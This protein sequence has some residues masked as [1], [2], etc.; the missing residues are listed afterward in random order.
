MTSWRW[1]E[2]VDAPKKKNLVHG[3]DQSFDSG[4]DCIS[5]SLTKAVRG[6]KEEMHKVTIDHHRIRTMAPILP[7]P[8]RRRYEDKGLAPKIFVPKPGEITMRP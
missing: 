1:L 3:A 5:I 8:N 7:L 6:K 2:N 4:V